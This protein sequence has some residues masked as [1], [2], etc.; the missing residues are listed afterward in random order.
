MHCRSVLKQSAVLW[1][2]AL[3]QENKGNLGK[4]AQT[5]AKFILKN[6][7]KSYDQSLQISFPSKERKVN[8][9]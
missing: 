6:N 9:S 2:G 1:Q 3:T 4:N 7:Y 5:F 8:T